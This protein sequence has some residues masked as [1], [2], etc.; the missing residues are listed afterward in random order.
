MITGLL[1]EAL[2][3]YHMTGFNLGITFEHA[4]WARIFQT[5][6][7]AFLFIPITQAAYVNLPPGKSGNAA[8]EVAGEVDESGSVGI[9]VTTTIVA[10]R[11][12][13]HQSRLGEHV[14]AFS[15]QTT[16]ALGQISHTL[17]VGA[18]AA[19]GALARIYEMLI[20]EAAML[21]YL[22]AF[23]FMA[24]GTLCIVPLAFFL[25]KNCPKSVVAPH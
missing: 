16:A 25:P 11:S 10:Q 23:L 13:F 8:A 20:R 9:A 21:A 17:G 22:D 6:G 1:L 24:I 4:V 3:L 7:L 2:S 5:V 14:S 18:G 15:P 19:H 12:Q